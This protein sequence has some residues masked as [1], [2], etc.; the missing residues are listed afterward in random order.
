MK[1]GRILGHF[2]VLVPLLSAAQEQIPG[3]RSAALGNSTFAIPDGWSVFTNQAGLAWQKDYWV[4]VHHENKFFVKNLGFSAIGADI[5]VKPGTFGVGMTH[6]GYNQFNQTR[7]SL[8]FGMLL[9]EQFAAGIGLNYH[10]VHLAGSYGN[11]DAISAEGGIIYKPTKKCG[12][13]VH[14][15]NPTASTLNSKD[16]LPTTFGIGMFF[17]PVKYLL[18]TFQGDDNSVTKPVFRTGFEYNPVENMSVRAGFTSNPSVVSFGLGWQII[19][20]N[21][22]LAFSY[23]EILG[24]TPLISVS[25]QFVKKPEVLHKQAE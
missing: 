13:G 17:K 16:D 23:H 1:F 12:I 19:G 10:Y 15:F 18:L 24:Y 14:V 7:A 22:D 2:F 3:C 5:P 20:I 11:S 8:N 4:G 25:Y 6:F 21:L 9:T